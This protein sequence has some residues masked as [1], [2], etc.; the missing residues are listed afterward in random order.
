MIKNETLECGSGVIDNNIQQ[1]SELCRILTG[2]QNLDQRSLISS[3]RSCQA[4][5][6]A[7]L[8]LCL[9]VSCPIFAMRTGASSSG[10]Q[11]VAW[12]PHGI[13]THQ[14]TSLPSSR[15]GYH[16]EHIQQQCCQQE[17]QLLH[18]HMSWLGLVGVSPGLLSGVSSVLG[19]PLRALA[20]I[21]AHSVGYKCPQRLA[22]PHHW[23]TQIGLREQHSG[24]PQVP[25]ACLWQS[26]MGP[27]QRSRTH[28]LLM[29]TFGHQRKCR[30]L[31]V[32]WPD[33]MQQWQ[34]GSGA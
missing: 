12:F 24:I 20:I 23:G 26:Q 32:W 10:G 22:Y 30:S 29:P 13:R 34:R 4:C 33:L 31:W 8:L 3:L 19:S 6:S 14:S 25:W 28:C 15:R 18:L 9:Q 1:N 2:N 17:N 11:L 5:F 27:L 7:C 16:I 21:A